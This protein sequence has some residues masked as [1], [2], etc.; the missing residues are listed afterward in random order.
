MADWGLIT[1]NGGYSSVGSTTASTH[2]TTLT[3]GAA[4]TK[5]NF[6]QL[7]ASTA[8]PC[9]AINLYALTSSVRYRWYFVDVAVGA[10]GSEV[11]IIPN[12][13]FT[14]DAGY[15]G[16]PN[17]YHFNH[18]YI[19]AGTRISARFQNAG[20]TE[21]LDFG[22]GIFNSDLNYHTEPSI[23]SCYGA[24]LAS[25]TGTTV[26]THASN[27]TKGNWVELSASCNKLD[28]LIISAADVTDIGGNYLIDIGV[29]AAGS[30]VVVADNI[31]MRTNGNVNPAFGLIYLPLSIASGTRISIRAQSNSGNSSFNAVLYGY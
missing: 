12:L 18:I 31:P 4:H 25:T 5:G 24:V 6:S 3:A 20:A 19:P 29:G 11:V 7:I 9:S 1:K 30:E 16:V 26:A 14:M 27:N 13:M 8:Y 23:V 15:N 22:A 21:T 2:L 10:A 28:M 17:C